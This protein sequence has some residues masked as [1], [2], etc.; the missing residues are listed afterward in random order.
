M[1]KSHIVESG[2]VQPF[3]FDGNIGSNGRYALYN[4]EYG[5]RFSAGVGFAFADV[6]SDNGKRHKQKIQNLSNKNTIFS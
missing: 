6:R 4:K 5:S 3:N 1:K 2:N